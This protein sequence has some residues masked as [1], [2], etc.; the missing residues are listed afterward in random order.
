MRTGSDEGSVGVYRKPVSGLFFLFSI[1]ILWGCSN[2]PKRPVVYPNAKAASAGQA[3]MRRDVEDCMALARQ[4]GVRETQQ[5][6]IARD[7]ATGALIGGVAAG[8]W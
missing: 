4:H 7:T 8:T 2:A 3:Q 1:L 5:D 6:N